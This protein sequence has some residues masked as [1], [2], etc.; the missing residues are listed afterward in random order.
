M[1]REAA[2]L[3]DGEKAEIDL[4]GRRALQARF[5]VK[6]KKAE[7]QAKHSA[8]TSSTARPRRKPW[9]RAAPAEA[10]HA[11][12]GR[13]AHR[14]DDA[15][16]GQQ[17]RPVNQ[18]ARQVREAVRWPEAF[19]PGPAREAALIPA[20]Q[21]LQRWE[22]W[23]VSEIG[24]SHS[25]PCEPSSG[26]VPTS[27]RTPTTTRTCSSTRCA[28]PASA[29]ERLDTEPIMRILFH[30]NR[31][32]AARRLILPCAQR[33]SARSPAPRR[34]DHARLHRRRA[35][36]LSPDG[37]WRVGQQSTKSNGRLYAHAPLRALYP[38]LPSPA[39]RRPAHTGPSCFFFCAA[40]FV[41]RWSRM[42]PLR[43]PSCPASAPSAVAGAWK[44]HTGITDAPPV[45]RLRRAML[46]W[47]L[48]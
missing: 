13:G 36:N 20:T 40:P 7:K 5:G 37:R 12:A 14:R 21:S 10:H 31:I 35:A 11:G 44:Q 43:A 33:R 23:R 41:T 9:P 22:A 47:L 30:T 4:R 8:T 18:H 15:E 45:P 3:S 39:G 2:T 16:H 1:L 48:T 46:C 34:H 19:V 42:N 26:H 17:R 32:R 28:R 25:S 6:A 24:S 27:R 38:A 29:V